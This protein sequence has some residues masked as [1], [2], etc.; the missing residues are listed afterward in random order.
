MRSALPPDVRRWLCLAA[1]SPQILG[2]APGAGSA[3]SSLRA[4]ALKSDLLSN[5]RAEEVLPLQQAG[6][7]GAQPEPRANPNNHKLLSGEA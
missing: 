2:C 7:K 1:P 5:R 6:R 4:V 3:H